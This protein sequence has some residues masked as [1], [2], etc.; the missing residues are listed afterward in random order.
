MPTRLINC[1][2]CS[3]WEFIDAHRVPVDH[4][5]DDDPAAGGPGRACP[6]A[7]A[8]PSVA[9]GFEL[10]T[11]I[12]MQRGHRTF[13]FVVSPSLVPT[14][15]VCGGS[16]WP[17]HRNGLNSAPRV[18]PRVYP[19]LATRPN[20]GS[21]AR[22]NLH[23]TPDAEEDCVGLYAARSRAECLEEDE[24]WKDD[25][26]VGIAQDCV[27][28]WIDAA[29]AEDGA[30]DGPYIGKVLRHWIA[31]REATPPV[32]LWLVLY[33]LQGIQP[34]LLIWSKARRKVVQTRKCEFY[35]GSP[36]RQLYGND[37]RP[38]TDLIEA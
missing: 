23:P 37:T 29:R 36:R 30:S 4:K 10:P 38:V 5:L 25:F 6:K 2:L 19:G 34:T 24:V 32:Q 13:H 28:L 8:E 33:L 22:T 9:R 11:R 18:R 7:V 31:M 35:T 26:C 16:Q 3:S 27:N 17:N 14:Q 15:R 1:A 21:T 20:L 12:H